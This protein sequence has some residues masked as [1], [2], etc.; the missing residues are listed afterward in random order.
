[1]RKVLALALVAAVAVAVSV[2]PISGAS[3]PAGDAV[4]AKKKGKKKCG[5][6]KGKAKGKSRPQSPRERLEEKREKAGLKPRPGRAAAEAAKKKGKR[7]CGKKK[8]KGRGR[9]GRGYQVVGANYVGETSEGMRFAMST[10]KGG[11]SMSFEI[12]MTCQQFNNG[13]PVTQPQETFVPVNMEVSKPGLYGP[14]SGNFGASQ[15]GGMAFTGNVQ[16]TASKSAAQGTATLNNASQQSGTSTYA[17]QGRTVS[18]NVAKT[19]DRCVD[20]KR[21]LSIPC[22]SGKR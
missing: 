13:A 8:G 17:C 4:A 14:F 20:S 18:F 19:S 12:G 5:K 16:G 7:K 9:G 3:A 22:P 1:M 15:Q 21:G 10:T 2:A 11:G 6:K